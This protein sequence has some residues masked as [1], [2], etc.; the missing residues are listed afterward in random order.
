[1]EEEQKEPKLSEREKKLLLVRTRLEQ[2]ARFAESAGNN[3]AFQ[4]KLAEEKVRLEHELAEIEKKGNWP[5]SIV[6][7]GTM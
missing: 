7:R 4:K 3:E 6:P 5:S 2:N 1:M